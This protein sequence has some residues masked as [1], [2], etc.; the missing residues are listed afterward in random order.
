MSSDLAGRRLVILGSMDEFVRLASLAKKRGAF[1][2]VCDGY[3]N[4]P[5]KAIADK[6]YDI[7]VRNVDAIIEMCRHENVDGVVSSFS[8]VLAES[9][10][11]VRM[12]LGMKPY[13]DS[14]KLRYLRDKTLMKEMF[15]EL[16]VPVPYSTVLHPESVR[17]DLAHMLF[18]VVIKPTDSYGS[19]GVFLMNDESQVLDYFAE[20]SQYSSDGCVLC[21]EYNDGHEFN[22]MNWIVNGEPVVLNIAD[23]EKTQGDALKTP[24]VSRIV[25]PS[26]LIDSVL[27]EARE[28]VGRVARYLEID[29][30]PLCMQFFWSSKRGIQVCECAGR[31]FG[32]EHELLD[33][34]GGPLVENI[35]LD[36]VFN[37]EAVGE[38]LSKH[39]PHLPEC[40]AGLYFHGKDGLI[41]SIEGMPSV[42]DS[43]VDESLVYYAVGER[44]NHESGGN[45]PYAARFYIH[46]HDYEGLDDKTAS[47]FETF[48][49]LG[50]DGAGLL[51][52]NEIGRY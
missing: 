4:G 33:I 25:Y 37:P 32:Y 2:I 50:Q 48:R 8:D 1:V 44:I 26:R 30:G 35:L 17:E 42:A 19:R 47:I 27:D 20:V 13:L 14:D 36:S 39:N 49:M 7:D 23:R 6:S 3:R 11:S 21:E 34:A 12:A 45:R 28:I 51:L 52:K 40:S 31:I 9:L 43:A 29:N 38:S 41:S 24:F 16:N 10:A 5:A 22:M 18:P 15:R 46:S